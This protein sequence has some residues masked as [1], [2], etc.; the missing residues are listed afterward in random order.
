VYFNPTGVET[1]NAAVLTVTGNLVGSNIL[2]TTLSRVISLNGSANILDSGRPHYIDNLAI[3]TTWA[4]VATVNVPRLTLEVNTTTGQTR[5]INNTSQSI[6][7]AYY[8]ILS[9]SGALKPSGAGSWNSLDDQNT[10]GGAWLENSPSANQLIESNFTGSTT[11]ASGGGTLLLGGAFTVGGAQDLVARW[12]T[13]EGFDGL[14]N[15][16]NVVY[17]TG[18]AAPVPEPATWGLLAAGLVAAAFARKHPLTR[19]PC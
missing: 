11:I 3:G 17:V 18:A 8:E 2:D 1:T 19:Q 5:L 16:A 15:V 14:L 10:S 9:T 6:P 7:L 4:D 12:G 13:K